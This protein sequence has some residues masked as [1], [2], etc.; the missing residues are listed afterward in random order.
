MPNIHII[1]CTILCALC[2]APCALC[3]V[4]AIWSLTCSLRDSLL[5]CLLAVA[6]AAAAFFISVVSLV[7]SLHKLFLCL[8][9]RSFDVYIKCVYICE[10]HYAPCFS[11]LTH[12]LA[13]SCYTHC[14]VNRVSQQSNTTAKVCIHCTLYVYVHTVLWEKML[15]WHKPTSA[16]G[17]FICQTKRGVWCLSAAVAVAA[18]AVAAD[19]VAF[20]CS[21]II[22]Y[23]SL[24]FMF[25]TC[26]CSLSFSFSHSL[27]FYLF[28]FFS[29]A[30]YLFTHSVAWPVTCSLAHTFMPLCAIFICFLHIYPCK[31]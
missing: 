16:Q 15:Y 8:Y 14:N 7:F 20:D 23:I 9:A 18:T 22:V 24:L 1:F 6:V 12:S 4:H 17:C 3:A 11:S 10:Y 2:C 26:F 30:A 31:Y 5:V 25:G 29:S 21:R 28:F 27:S 19:R 13:H